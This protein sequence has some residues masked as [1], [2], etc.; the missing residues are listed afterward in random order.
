MA[1]VVIR[2]I[3]ASDSAWSH[4]KALERKGAASALTHRIGWVFSA[5]VEAPPKRF[6]KDL[7]DNG[8][9][10]LPRGQSTGFLNKFSFGSNG[11]NRHKP[12]P[13]N[14]DRYSAPFVCTCEV[15]AYGLAGFDQ[16]VGHGTSW[17]VDFSGRDQQENAKCR[18]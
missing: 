15:V 9:Q 17:F 2:Q 4:R 6:G 16:A 1:P 12:T 8:W 13:L 5:S 18:K 10:Q 3:E 7:S 14:P 11:S